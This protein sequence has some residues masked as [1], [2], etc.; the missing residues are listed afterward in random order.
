MVNSRF[1]NDQ[2]VSLDEFVFY[3]SDEHERYL[4]NLVNQLFCN[5]VPGRYKGEPSTRM[6]SKL[7]R[8]LNYTRGKSQYQGMTFRLDQHLDE[9]LS[10]E[11][12]PRNDIKLSLYFDNIG[13]ETKEDVEEAALFHEK[14]G[15]LTVYSGTVGDVL[16][17][18]ESFL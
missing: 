9:V 16:V 8:L 15:K 2:I 3:K 7:S 12:P 5:T 14:E 18:L 1:K 6:I 13:E 10:I 17:E 4:I 11:F